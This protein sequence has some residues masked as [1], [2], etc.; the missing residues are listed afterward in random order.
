MP[1]SEGPAGAVF[2]YHAPA[3]PREGTSAREIPIGLLLEPLDP[4]RH[5]MDDENMLDL[6]R[7]IRESGLFQNLC[8]IP[9]MSA[10]GDT[11]NRVP[12]PDYDTHVRKGGR[13][14][15]AAGHRRL[16]ACRAIGYDPVKCEIFLSL[17]PSEDEIMAGENTHREDPTDFD[18]AVLYSKWL[19]EESM[20]EAELSRRAGKSLFFIYARAELLNGYK[21]VCDALHARKINFSVAKALNECDEPEYMQHFLNMAIDNGLTSKYV[22]AMVNE[23]KAYRDMAQ[24]AQPKPAQPLHISAPAFQKIECLLCGDNQS[25]NLQ[26]VMMCGA[27]IERIKAARAAAEA[28][29][30]DGAPPQPKGAG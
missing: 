6:Q 15:V 21:E 26:T 8:V 27:D 23:R 25:Y 1:P 13:F 11:W 10:T 30:T 16:L 3:A 22:R 20:T 29:E 19:K 18:L 12:M 14:R 28:V 4:M 7:S 2:A 24:P 17:F 5:N 9:V